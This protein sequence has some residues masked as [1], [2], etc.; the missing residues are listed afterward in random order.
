MKF[1]SRIDAWHVRAPATLEL[2]RTLP[3]E[4]RDG[5][6]ENEASD[7]SKLALLVEILENCIRV[8]YAAQR[9]CCWGVTAAAAAA[10]AHPTPPVVHI[11]LF[12]GL[13]CCPDTVVPPT[14]EFSSSM[15]QQ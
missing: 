13:S 14:F 6:Q 11:Y 2:V 1:T 7:P 8:Y 4:S 5:T 15:Q 9:F 10:A 12:A 3:V